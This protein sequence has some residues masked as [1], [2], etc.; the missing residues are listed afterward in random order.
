MH[1]PTHPELAALHAAH[2]AQLQQR[3]ETLLAEHGYDALAIAA[4]VEKYAF[5]DD[6]AYPFQANPHLLHWAPLTQHPGSWLLVRPGRR[7]LLV[8]LQPEDYWHA[9]PAAPAGYW[10][11]GFE[12]QL[13]RTPQQAAACLQAAAPARVAVIGEPDA[14]LPGFAA[15]DNPEA[16]LA[17]L[18]FA[19]GIK[20]PYECQL[21]RAAS[22]RAA[23]G[24]LAAR[25]A[26]EAGGSEADI[27][28]AYLTASGQAERE[29][30][31][32]NIVGLGAHGA[33]L[34]WQHQD[35]LPPAQPTSLLIDAGAACGGYAAD[36]TRSWLHPAA[37]AG[38]AR[39]DFAALLAGMERLQLALVD[40]VREGVD[41]V[42]IHL[43]AHR[44]I[45]Q[46]LLEQG[47]LRGLSAEAAVAQGLSACFFPHGVG[48]LLGLQVHDVAGLQID[49][50]GTR[51]ERPAGHPYLRLTR[52]LAAGMA[53]TIEPG[54]YFVPLLL[55]ALQ[56][57]G[58]SGHVD[59]ARVDALRAFGGIR[60]EDDV[61]CNGAGQAPENLTRAA[62]AALG[63]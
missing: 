2:L 37:A 38:A 13:V 44:R 32:G 16:L 1:L 50:A 41:Y 6:R 3:C 45:A 42:D 12:L 59:W 24:H 43:S 60:I 23:L 35:A 56:Q 27:H 39:D 53:V 7:P 22:R 21:M 46:L 51:R 4:G 61:V 52:V 31:Y 33:V 15:P 28:N 20:S 48:H 30:P 29:L 17:A 55:Q 5:L 9:P 47:L 34:H 63:A 25:A 11:A 40:E 14:A 58:L 19:R 8:Y 57:G 62:F 18:H 54:L 26:F 49:A 10:L 36:I